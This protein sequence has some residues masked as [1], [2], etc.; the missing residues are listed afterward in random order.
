MKQSTLF[1]L[2]I[3]LMF[4]CSPSYYAKIQKLPLD[5]S[6]KDDEPHYE[7]LE[8]WAAH[9]N[10][11][12]PSDSISLAIEDKNRDTT[13]DVFFLHPT[14]L[15]GKFKGNFNGQFSDDTLNAKTDYSSI[16]Y[17]ASV[18]NNQANIFAPRYR[19]ANIH[20]YFYNDTPR[21][22]QAFD[23]AYAD[24]K[25]AFAY[26][27]SL[28]RNKPYIIAA[29]SQGTQHAKRLINEM[30]DGTPLQ[31]K[32]VMAYLIGMPITDGTFKNIKPCADSTQTGCYV[33][34]RTYRENYEGPAYISN[35]KKVTV[36]NPLNWKTDTTLADKSLHK[37]A[38]L[39]SYNKKI[40][41]PSNARVHGNILWVSR[42]RFPGSALYTTKNYHVG[43]YNLFYFNIRE[44]VKRRI[45]L[46]KQQ[47]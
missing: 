1:I 20:M 44:D 39:M 21:A 18:F 40:P 23:L 14:T 47:H 45:D 15:T 32:L 3:I 27:L 10:K 43:D 6:I 33:S 12:D 31:D 42:P 36:T 5:L 26:Y 35:E 11:W 28:N 9:P 38:L 4:G 30:I 41:A 46:Y 8:Y 37:G 13:V 22:I 2:L 34:W 17:Q 7:K 19:Q 29:H 24:I 16:L 25:K